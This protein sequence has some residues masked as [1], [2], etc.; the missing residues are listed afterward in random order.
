MNTYSICQVFV[1]GH[2][3]YKHMFFYNAERS[4]RFSKRVK[5]NKFEKLD[6][7]VR[8]DNSKHSECKLSARGN[9]EP[10]MI[11]LIRKIL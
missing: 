8:L 3:I 9:V 6:E 1:Q 5:D 10:I 2:D 7:T 4:V 11:R